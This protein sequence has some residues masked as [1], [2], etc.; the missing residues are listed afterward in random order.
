VLYSGY[1]DDTTLFLADPEDLDSAVGIFDRFSNVSGMKLN[2]GKCSIVPFGISKVADP[3]LNCPFTW[4]SDSSE[5]EKLLG[6]PVGID[7]DEDVLWKELLS[8]LS[9]SVKH[10][11]AQKLSVFGRIHAARS[12]IGG[13]AWFLATMVPP[14]PKGLKKLTALLWAYVQNNA[15]IDVA[16]SNAHYSPWSRQLLVQQVAAGGLNAQDPA[17]FLN[18]IQAR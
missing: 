9:D 16:E 8:K 12:Y 6:V 14:N 18:A 4:L 10:W 17:T 15:V 5:L 13:K 1:A 3:P 7:F 11:A 2:H